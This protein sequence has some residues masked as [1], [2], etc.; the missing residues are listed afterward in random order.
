[1]EKETV[2]IR[3]KVSIAGPKYLCKAGKEVF[4]EPEDAKRF[5]KG[6]YCDY[7]NPKEDPDCKK[8]QAEEAK[9]RKAEEDKIK[10]AAAEAKKRVAKENKEKEN[11]KATVG[12][13]EKAI[14]Q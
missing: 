13:A 1:M 2:R 14:T 6:G 8:T 4:V 12:H 7:V 9:K 3:M 10:K 5:K 11:E